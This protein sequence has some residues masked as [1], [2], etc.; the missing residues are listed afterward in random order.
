MYLPEPCT[1]NIL[2]RKQQ[3]SVALQT[4]KNSHNKTIRES[5]KES[6]ITNDLGPQSPLRWEKIASGVYHQELIHPARYGIA[7]ENAANGYPGILSV[8]L[9][10][11]LN[12][13]NGPNP[14]VKIDPKQKWSTQSRAIVR[15]L[16]LRLHFIFSVA[17]WEAQTRVYI[18]VP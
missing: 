10:G 13:E 17:M 7:K 12:P 1:S 15:R 6:I 8:S 3:R 9:H 11:I 16:I 5:S 4:R 14:G 2:Q 18:L